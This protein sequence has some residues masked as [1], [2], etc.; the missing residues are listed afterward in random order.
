MEPAGL[1]SRRDSVKSPLCI[2][3]M[4][5]CYWRLGVGRGRLAW[6]VSSL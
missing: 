3:S 2:V 4:Q 1:G 5:G 6:S